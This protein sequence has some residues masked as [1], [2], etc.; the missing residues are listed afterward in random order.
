MVDFQT[1]LPPH[2]L[3]Y[4]IVY[5]ALMCT[6]IIDNKSVMIFLICLAMVSGALSLSIQLLVD[7]DLFW[8]QIYF[9]ST[10]LVYQNNERLFPFQ[11][12]AL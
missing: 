8:L 2:E 3:S 6:D 10:V 12:E 9:T 5:D 1:K 4:D 7:F 11:C